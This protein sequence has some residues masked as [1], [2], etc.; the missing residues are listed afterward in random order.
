MALTFD[1]GA[2]NDTLTD[3]HYSRWIEYVTFNTMFVGMPEI[4]E[5]N[6]SQFIMRV[7]MFN[8]ARGDC[9]YNTSQLT[10]AVLPFIGLRTNA[11][12]YTDAAFVKRLKDIQEDTMRS[13][14]MGVAAQLNAEA[15]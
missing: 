10:E 9:V 14:R 4:T 6:Y 13:I 5:L 1:Y 2:C 7:M 12:P 8:A 3:E 15:L 11:S